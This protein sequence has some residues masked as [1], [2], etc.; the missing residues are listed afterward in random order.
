MSLFQAKNI[1]AGYGDVV[2][3]DGVS[4]SIANGDLV[5]IVGP[6]GSGKSTLL[7]S[8]VGLAR[9]FSGQV[10]YDGR[11]VTRIAPW[12]TVNIGLGYVPQVNNVFTNL[13]VNENLEMG[14]Y[15][16]R[17]KAGIKS[18]LEEIYQ[19]FPE[20]AAR[21][22]ARAET[23]S[24]GER[25]LLAIARAMMAHPRML[26]LDEPLAFLSPKASGVVLNRLLQIQA[27][28]TSLLLVEQNTVKALQNAS[29]GYILNEG[30]CVM[31]GK[32]P[33]LLADESLRERFLG[34]GK[35]V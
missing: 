6:N 25:Q 29:Y 30:R 10:L 18:D 13:T 20:L 11:D 15:C 28:G 5:A 8:L 7:K 3:V 1:R 33:E 35:G 34:L 19:R 9:L 2:I 22:K 21:K 27:E 26:L 4:L 31:E 32:G 17:D 23:L 24:G 16:R 12:Q 14:A